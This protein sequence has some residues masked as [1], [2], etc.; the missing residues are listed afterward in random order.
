MN[1]PHQL[2]GTIETCKLKKEDLIELTSLIRESFPKPEKT[3]LK[4]ALHLAEVNIEANSIDDFLK[5]PNLPDYIDNQLLITAYES[6]SDKSIDE[7][8]WVMVQLYPALKLT[9]FNVKGEEK[10]WV[11]GTHTLLSRLFRRNRIRFWFFRKKLF[12]DYDVFR[13]MSDANILLVSFS[14]VYFL[15]ARDLLLSYV[16]AGILATWS[17]LRK[18]YDDQLLLKSINIYPKKVGYSIGRDDILFFWAVI[19]SIAAVI[20]AIPVVGSWF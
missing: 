14:L 12:G 1:S 18:L 10:N 16:L 8:R 7:T 2:A 20:A 15:V 19:S 6:G 5:H 11:L 17:L 4:F 3:V 9:F 13:L